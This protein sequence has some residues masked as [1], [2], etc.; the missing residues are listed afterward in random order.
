MSD[1]ICAVIPAAGRGTRLGLN[2]PKLLAPIDKETT[3]WSILRA[4]L[5]ASADRIHL[6]VAPQWAGVFE[7]LLAK[8]PYRD[9][10]SF[11]I[12][13]KPR[14]MGDAIFGA[15]AYWSAAKTMLVVWGDQ[16]HISTNTIKR[17][18]S[19]HMDSRGA[20]CTI[21]AVL[22]ERPYVQ[23]C[24]DTTGRL[25]EIRETREGA[26]CDPIGFSDVGTF[27]LEVEGLRDA[28]QAYQLQGKAGALTGEVNF[29][30]FLPYLARKG[31]AI[32]RITVDDPIE[33]RG[34]NSLDDL[35][36]FQ[37]IYR[38]EK[39]VQPAARHV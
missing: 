21:P 24:F 7:A 32:S 37:Q 34:V 4:K 10:L 18:L 23:Y 25:T 17:A 36:F 5:L 16:I 11:S 35:Q 22:L 26:K 38:S 3:I 33:A 31:W 15:E 19:N 13:T 39:P 20:Y 9:R 30:P 1:S 6:V 12:Q 29:L 8:D 28:W 2:V 27:A 14:G